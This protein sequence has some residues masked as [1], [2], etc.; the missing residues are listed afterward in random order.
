M[1]RGGSL[2]MLHQ[3]NIQQLRQEIVEPVP[4][5]P[6]SRKGNKLTL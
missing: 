6:A 5:S 2:P 1:E 3:Q 4:N